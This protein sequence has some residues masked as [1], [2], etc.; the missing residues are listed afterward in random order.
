MH[1]VVPFKKVAVIGAGTMG[2]GIAGQIANANQEVLLLD[3]P[4]DEPNS[5]TEDA[6]KKLIKSDP[7]ALMHKNR[8][9]LIKIGNIRDN[10]E[11]LSEC[12]LIIEAVVERLDI[13][14]DLYKRINEVINEDCVITS[15]TST[16]PIKLLIEDMPLSFRKRFAIT[17]YFNPVR[18]MRLLELVRGHDTNPK[19]ISKLADYNDRILGKGV[20]ACDDTPGFL[21]NRVGVYALQVGMDEAFKLG[22]SIEEADALMGRP[23]GIPKTGVFGLYDLIGVDLMADVVDTL[24]SILPKS[25]LFHKVGSKNIP[26]AELIKQMIQDGFTGN[27]GKGGFYRIDENEHE[28]IVDIHT[29]K[30][31]PKIGK[32]NDK[33]QKAAELLEQ[34]KETLFHLINNSSNN[35]SEK[36]Y[37]SFCRNVLGRILNYS[38]SLIPEIT[39][40]PQN[41]D[42]AMKLGFN[43]IRGPFEIIDALGKDVA[44]ELFIES[45]LEIPKSMACFPFY[46]VK[47]NKLY[48]SNYSNSNNKPKSSL[49]PIILPENA[50][51]FHLKRQTL[52]PVFENRSASLFTIDDDIRLIEFHSKANTLDDF[53]MEVVKAATNNP[54]NGIIVHNDAQHFSSGVNL[55]AFLSLIRSKNWEGIDKFLLKFQHAVK[56][57]KFSSVPVV[58]APSGMA[59]GGGFE[60]LLHSDK[61]IAHTNS[62]LGLVESGVGLIP[63][64]G[65]VK[66]T[67]LRCYQKLNDE[68]EAAWKTWMQI[69]YG[70]TGTSP[71]KSSELLYFINDRDRTE[72]N[73]DYLV[74]S[75]LLSIKELNEK[76]YK[77]PE[78]KTIRLPGNSILKKME[79]FM[80]NGI[81][82]GVFYPHDKTVAMEVASVVANKKENKVITVKED[83]LFDRERKAFINLAKTKPTLDRISALIEKGVSL[84]N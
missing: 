46:R 63:G 26:T 64:G 48:V 1:K 76:G 45:D 74:N 55:N 44:N 57:L 10:F 19:I 58:G 69:G 29:H 67:Y 62:V 49:K 39:S 14:K 83:E 79:D 80:D 61:I 32:L 72:M 41:I 13:K 54:G 73:R 2:S 11:S 65:G 84:R 18:F 6:I 23:M 21:G 78:P 56:S 22:L 77:K 60:V 75:A 4:G 51:R 47:K 16:I 31:C 8:T 52:K 40:S 34:G 27:K 33:A 28:L 20:V 68:E 15:N 82:K 3:I 17:H 30:I 53:S 71:E 81:D 38:A 66:E 7:P 9:N 5:I 25:D 36:K 37:T 35:N 70:Q 43:W 12:D 42:D 59:I 50:M 24:G